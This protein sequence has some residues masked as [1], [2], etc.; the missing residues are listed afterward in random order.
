V[1]QE[2]QGALKLT[3]VALVKEGRG[4]MISPAAD[5]IIDCTNID[6]KEGLYGAT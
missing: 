4:G 3:K 6:I 5:H 2:Q 1:A